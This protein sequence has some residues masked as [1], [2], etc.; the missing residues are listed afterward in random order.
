[1]NKVITYSLVIVLALFGTALMFTQADRQFIWLFPTEGIVNT[2]RLQSD[3]TYEQTFTVHQKNISRFGIYV[4]PLTEELPAGNISLQLYRG[5]VLL[6]EGTIPAVVAAP[7]SASFI[8]FPTPIPVTD[9][10]QLRFQVR[11]PVALTGKLALQTKIQDE[12]F[13]EDAT[14][15]LDGEP[16]TDPLGYEAYYAIR[17]PLPLYVGGLSLLAALGIALYPM[18][19]RQNLVFPVYAIGIV[20][21]ANIPFFFQGIIHVPLLVL[22]WAIVYTSLRFLAPFFT[23]QARLLLAHTFAFTSWWLLVLY[24]HKPLFG[25]GYLQMANHI[26]DFLFDPNQIV[27][28]P[29]GAYVGIPVG[30]FALLAFFVWRKVDMLKNWKVAA[31]T[32]SII[33][34]YIAPLLTAVGVIFMAAVGMTYLN[35]FLGER[36]KLVSLLM[37]VLVYVIL[38]DTFTVYSRAIE[39]LL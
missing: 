15:L 38:L 28:S 23:V 22:E 39:A 20:L 29:A 2:V 7:N 9:G 5:S 10:E 14:F 1:M 30:L 37:Y 25:I 6:G 34:L 11:T 32:I 31:I 16:Q 18:L 36:D 21:I 35:R 4:R 17:P 24:A 19:K 26:K 13:N 33:G 27:L 3:H 12:S 8:R